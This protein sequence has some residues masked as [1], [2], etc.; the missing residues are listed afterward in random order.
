M[1][2]W[3]KSSPGTPA[4]GP[5]DRDQPILETSRKPAMGRHKHTA[6]N[7]TRFLLELPSTLTPRTYARGL[8]EVP[9]YKRSLCIAS[10]PGQSWNRARG[11][12]GTNKNQTGKS[13]VLPCGCRRGLRSTGRDAGAQ[14]SPAASQTSASL[15]GDTR[16]QPQDTAH[17][18]NSG[19][20]Q[21][22]PR[23]SPP[24]HIGAGREHGVRSPTPS[25]GTGVPG[26]MQ[27][28]NHR[29]QVEMLRQ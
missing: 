7:R 8:C 4:E 12:M 6:A 1:F 10:A 14:P 27:S 21:Q 17:A 11:L 2:Y 20:V 5:E 13:H 29:R 19:S 3:E 24:R 18:V 9:G 16:L 15:C 25:R 26:G 22:W 28:Q 23:W